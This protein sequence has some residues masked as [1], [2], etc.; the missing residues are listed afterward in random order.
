MFRSKAT[1][2][3]QK[4]AVEKPAR[5]R[6]ETRKDQ[7]VRRS[8]RSD[9]PLIRYFQETAAELRKVAWPSRETT[10]RLTMIVLGTTVVFA[11][12]LG[13]LDVLFQRLAALLIRAG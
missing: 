12:F 9:N 3:E 7:P 6:R 5:K 10:F 13:G 2:E 1:D 4:Q 8:S 11:I